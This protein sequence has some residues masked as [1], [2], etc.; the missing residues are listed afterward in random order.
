MHR[1]TTDRIF[2]L[3]LMAFCLLAPYSPA[4]AA[5][6][7]STRANLAGIRDTWVEDLRAK[8]IE[9]ILKLYASDAVFLQPTGDRVAGAAA[10]R[11]LF[12]T[13]MATFDS[14]LTLHSQT[15][16]TSGDLAFD[17]G[18]FRET[19]TTIARGAKITATGSYLIIYKRQKNG[20]WL[21]IQH[22]FTG[23]PPRAS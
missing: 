19:L 21:I 4:A 20:T 22:V 23:T 13:V 15:V 5:P 6:K 18:D 9:H 10:L 3:V 11:A 2:A 7:T 17:S 8:R 16:E 1:Q 14:D 12:Q